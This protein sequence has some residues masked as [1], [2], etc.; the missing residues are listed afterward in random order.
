MA[1][2]DQRAIPVIRARLVAQAIPATLALRALQAIK[3]RK[4]LLDRLAAPQAQPAILVRA[5]ARTA[6][7]A[8]RATQVRMAS[9][10]QQAML[11]HKVYTVTMAR[12][13]IPVR[14]APTSAFSFR[15]LPI[16]ASLAKSG[17]TRAFL[18]FQP[19][20]RRG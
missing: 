10:A 4:A 2:R 15:R 16:L 20:N 3:V 8:L 18:K 12:P 1:L 19:A 17:A 5:V 14:P 6:Q 13:A 11:V 9:L 7:L